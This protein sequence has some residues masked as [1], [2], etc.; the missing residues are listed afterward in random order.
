MRTFIRNRDSKLRDLK[1]R[2]AT[3]LQITYL[4]RAGEAVSVK[5]DAGNDVTSLVL[6]ECVAAHSQA[7]PAILLSLIR[8]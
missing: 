7:D 1:G 4:I 3:L 8:Y 6:R 2:S 5:D